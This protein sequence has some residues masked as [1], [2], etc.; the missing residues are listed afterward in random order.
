MTLT[1]R[2]SAPRP[3][4]L[5]RDAGCVWLH[6]RAAPHTPFRRGCAAQTANFTEGGAPA[7]AHWAALPALPAVM[8][9]EVEGSAAGADSPLQLDGTASAAAAAQAPSAADGAA[10]ALLKRLD[11]QAAKE[12]EGPL[13]K[14]VAYGLMGVRR[15]T[16]VLGF[17]SYVHRNA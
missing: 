12:G 7:A 3:R 10:K 17:D 2:A 16:A 13:L 5:H 4:E 6:A 14:L 1:F 8:T 15:R 11:G 9:V